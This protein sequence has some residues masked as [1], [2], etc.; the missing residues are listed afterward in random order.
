MGDYT[1]DL[2]QALADLDDAM[3]G[4]F[5]SPETCVETLLN[6]V[7]ESLKGKVTTV[8]AADELS[9]KMDSEIVAINKC[10]TDISSAMAQVRNGTITKDAAKEIITPCVT[11]I[12]SKCTALGLNDELSPDNDICPKEVEMLREFVVGCKNLIDEHRS[13]LAGEEGSDQEGKA[14]TLLHG[15][16]ASM[17]SWADGILDEDDSAMEGLFGPTIRKEILHGTEMKTAN[18][19]YKQ[20]K[21]LRRIGSDTKA[22]ATM[23][24][25]KGIYEKLV[26]KAR[27]LGRGKS[28][29]TK[30]SMY[31]FTVGAVAGGSIEG[32]TTAYAVPGI[33]G[34]LDYLWDRIDSCQA[35][36]LKWTN[37][38]NDKEF[39][40]LKA[41]LKAEKKEERARIKE[42]TKAQKAANKE[43]KAAA[44]AAKKAAKAGDAAGATEALIAMIQYATEGKMSYDEDDLDAMALEATIEMDV[45]FEGLDADCEHDDLE[46]LEL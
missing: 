33:A 13:A 26:T 43:A 9:A 8:E 38:S 14:A 12:K 27:K 32:K 42:E 10:L 6:K 36:I 2:D 35:Y 31:G 30:S 44:K 18:A 46:E 23:Q 3:E 21:Q 45:A 37:K 24:K 5:C 29:H 11:T 22:V 17:E 39:K 28:M 34:V 4:M 20:A 40:D 7:R 25:A 16:P 41:Q 19:Y 15:A 1:S